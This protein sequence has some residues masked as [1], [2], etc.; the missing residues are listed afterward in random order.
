MPTFGFITLFPHLD[1]QGRIGNRPNR[2]NFEN[3][4]AKRLQLLVIDPHI[5]E[6]V[7]LLK[8]EVWE[9]FINMFSELKPFNLHMVCSSMELEPIRAI[10]MRVL[11]SFEY[12]G[13]SNM[14]L[15]DV[16]S[17]ILKWDRIAGYTKRSTLGIHVSH[18]VL[19]RSYGHLCSLEGQTLLNEITGPPCQ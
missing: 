18:L 4:S 10:M 12:H 6:Q 13:G 9:I 11:D 3:I 2:I 1:R 17:S 5:T 16:Q 15:H 8:L 7:L 14:V 19:R